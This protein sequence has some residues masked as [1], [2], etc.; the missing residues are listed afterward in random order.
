LINAK[1]L[2][3]G[4]ECIIEVEEWEINVRKKNIKDE[5]KYSDSYDH[6]FCKNDVISGTY[7][8]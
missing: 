7:K 1:V 6:S 4:P 5:V 3:E 8:W 2:T